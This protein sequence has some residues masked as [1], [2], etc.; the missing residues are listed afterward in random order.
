MRTVAR[1]TE[2]TAHGEDGRL[3][4]RKAKVVV[5]RI[6]PWSVLKFSLLFYSCLLLIFLLTL[7]ILFWVL[8]VTGVL[9]S[10]SEFLVGM[11]LGS[12]EAGFEFDGFWIFSRLAVAS[13]VGMAF[14][15]LVNLFLALLYNLISDVVGGISV[16]L[17]EKR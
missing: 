7:G 17:A 5:R 12:A 2:F 1:A 10:L 4:A 9:D 6:D 13:L 16:T 8:G 11:G 3:G 14:W 15:S